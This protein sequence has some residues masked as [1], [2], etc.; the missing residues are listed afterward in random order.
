MGDGGGVPF[1]RRYL[2]PAELLKDSRPFRVRLA[3]YGASNFAKERESAKAV[4]EAL[5]YRGGI[6]VK[7]HISYERSVEQFFKD[8]PIR[9][10]LD[11]I[12]YIYDRNRGIN[13]LIEKRYGTGIGNDEH[14]RWAD[15]VAKVLR[16]E[17]V[18]YRLDEHCGVHFYV[19]EEF[20]RNRVSTLASLD[21]P[22]LTNARVEYEAAFA[23]LDRGD[24]K[25]AVRSMFEAAEILAKL[26]VPEAQRL[27]REL[28]EKRLRAAC[29]AVAA[30]D[31]TEQKA[32]TAV[33]N[34]LID[35]VDGMHNYRHG[36]G[37]PEPVAPSEELA[38]LSLSI[39]SAYVRQLAAWYLRMP[40][41][42]G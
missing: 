16:E 25:A 17:C 13:A 15:F 42:I 31:P 41:N 37:S 3:Q 23:H 11:A 27:N 10:V 9:E 2:R 8:A 14:K 35:W 33:F 28:I 19:D 24:T 39:G 12:T 6:E 32:I 38:V 7:F 1:S 20:E 22:R 4:V 26:I 34:S 40:N 18:G 5:A 29:L 21:S 36:Q 30:Q